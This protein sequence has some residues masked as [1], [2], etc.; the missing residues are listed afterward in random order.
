[1]QF[2]NPGA[3]S[4]LLKRTII[5]KKGNQP[6]DQSKEGNSQIAPI[7]NGALSSNGR[8]HIYIYDGAEIDV[9]CVQLNWLRFQ[10]RNMLSTK[11]NKGHKSFTAL[12]QSHWPARRQKGPGHVRLVSGFR[13]S[14][15]SSINLGV[16]YCI[17]INGDE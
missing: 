11:Q 9:I 10:K 1:M 5:E 2:N 14:P 13:A 4:W 17:H 8:W 7:P 16:P 3:N 12:L 6:L 15:F